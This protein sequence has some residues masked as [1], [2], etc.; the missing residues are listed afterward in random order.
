MR[1]LLLATAGLFSAVAANAATVVFNFDD[2]GNN[3]A[4]PSSYGGAAWSGFTATSGFGQ[5]S[6]PN[7][8]YTS[9]PTGIL[10][11]ALG[12]TGLTFT[13]GVF[14]PSTFSVYS[15][16]GGTGT[17][18]GSLIIGNPPANPFAFFL[19]GVTFSGIGKSV[20]VTGGVGS[21]GWDDVTLSSGA[22]PEAQSWAMLIAGLGLTGAAMRRRR[23]AV[24]V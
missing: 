20:V 19:T 18:L 12:F 6:Q 13:T 17:L 14:T 22:V 7:L 9:A 10:D 24:T 4:V 1:K 8:A 23:V 21:V 15:G 2:L 5:T 11:Y 3:V 16:L